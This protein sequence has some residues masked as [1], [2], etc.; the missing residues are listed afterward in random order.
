LLDKRA[1][2]DPEARVVTEVGPGLDRGVAAFVR[3]RLA[4]LPKDG[5]AEYR[6]MIEAKA[7]SAFDDALEAGG[8]DRIEETAQRRP[9]TRAEREALAVVAVRAFESGDLPRAERALARIETV[10]SSP[11]ERRVFA[12]KRVLASAGRGDAAT[13][14]TALASFE[15]AGGDGNA[16]RIP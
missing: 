1:K 9:L 7:R 5:L 6:S 13:A 15:A 3:E 11:S 14:R 10:E 16:A 2:D 12:L 4:A 8:L